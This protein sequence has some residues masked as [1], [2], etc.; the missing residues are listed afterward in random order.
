MSMLI[1]LH[2]ILCFKDIFEGETFLGISLAGNANG[3]EE[4]GTE[5]Y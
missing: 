3:N 4:P 1:K 2:V 5:L